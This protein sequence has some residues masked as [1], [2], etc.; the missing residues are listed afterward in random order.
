MFLTNKTFNANACMYNVLSAAASG[1]VNRFVYIGPAAGPNGQG[2]LPTG[3][4]MGMPIGSLPSESWPAGRDFLFLLFEH[5]MVAQFFCFVYRR[6][7]ADVCCITSS[8]PSPPPDCCWL[9][10]PALALEFVPE[11]DPRAP[12]ALAALVPPGPRVL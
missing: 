4:P 8:S 9:L 3:V 1:R 10:L 2:S 11:A 7:V 12:C 6:L 5:K